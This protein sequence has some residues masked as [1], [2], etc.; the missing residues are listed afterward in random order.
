[1][2]SRYKSLLRSLML[3]CLVSWS[4]TK[5]LDILVLDGMGL[6]TMESGPQF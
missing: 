2:I 5:D 6:D 1:V 3:R 4:M